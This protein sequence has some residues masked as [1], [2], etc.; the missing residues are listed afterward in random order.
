MVAFCGSPFTDLGLRTFLALILFAMWSLLVLW[1]AWWPSVTEVCERSSN[2]GA[3]R[4]YL[5]GWT[6]VPIRDI[7]GVER[8]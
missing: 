3:E 7:G 4:Q 1:A 6:A 5:S 8:G 2:G